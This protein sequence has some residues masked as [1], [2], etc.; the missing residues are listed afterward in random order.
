[1]EQKTQGKKLQN[2]SDRGWTHNNQDEETHEDHPHISQRILQ[3][4]NVNAKKT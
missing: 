4:Q 3:E 2:N 1:M